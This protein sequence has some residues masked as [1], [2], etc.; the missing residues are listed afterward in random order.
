M[1]LSGFC[2]GGWWIVPIVL[3]IFLMIIC[4]L[5][6][7]RHGFRLCMGYFDKLVGQKDT[8]TPI[9]LLKK[10]YAKGEITSEEFGKIKRD[11]Q[12]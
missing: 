12:N 5:L 4:F 7:R 2:F 10:R 9:E 1:C 6:F 8:E 11:M 3:M